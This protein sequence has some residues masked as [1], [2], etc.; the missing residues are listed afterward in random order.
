MPEQPDKC[1]EHHML[2]KRELKTF[3]KQFDDLIANCEKMRCFFFGGI[4]QKDGHFSF[5]DKVNMMYDNQQKYQKEVK[6]FRDSMKNAMFAFIG[7]FG[8]LFITSL[9]GLGIQLKTISETEK[10]LSNVSQRQQVIKIDL[11][12]VKTKVNYP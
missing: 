2:L 3:K 6:E 4:D 7:I 5:V 9:V 8:V 11:E 12:K 10:S 1:Y